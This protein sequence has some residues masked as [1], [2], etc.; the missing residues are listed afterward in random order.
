MSA[1]ELLAEGK[2]SPAVDIYEV[3]R[4]LFLNGQPPQPHELYCRSDDFFKITYVTPAFRQY[5][6]DFLRKLAAGES[7]IYV[8]PALFGA[9][10]SH[11]LAFVLHL[12]AL[13]RGCN[14]KGGCVRSHLA[15]H[16]I[17]VSTPDVQRVPNVA[18]FRHD[19][20]PQGVAAELW[21]AKIKD[22]LRKVVERYSPLVVIFDETQYFDMQWQGFVPWLQTLAEVVSESRGVYLFVSYALF[23]EQ[24]PQ[25]DVPQS[26]LVVQRMSH[27]KV[28]LD[29]VKNIAYVF[30]RWAGINKPGQVDLA[31]LRQVVRDEKLAEFEREVGEAYPFNPLLLRVMHKLADESVAERTRVQLTREL[32]R[33][34]SRA[35]LNAGNGLVTFAD[36]PEP[37]EL[38]VIGGPNA[39]YWNG[40]LS[41]YEDDI[42]KLG[43]R[44]ALAVLRHILLATFLAK[45]LPVA[46]LYP[47]EDDLILGAYD[48]S[49]V[50]PVDVREVLDK[51]ATDVGLHVDKLGDGYVYWFVGDE[52]DAIQQAMSMFSSNDGLE[53]V[54]NEVASLVE[55]RAGPFS[56][57][58][59][60]GPKEK[61]LRKVRVISDK[62]VW[63]KI[64]QEVD[65]SVLAVDLQGW[66]VEKRRNNL[67]LIE[68]DDSAGISEDA[69]ELLARLVPVKSI[70]DSA[71]ALGRVV[72]AVN[73]VL[74]NLSDYF[75]EL[76]SDEYTDVQ[77]EMEQILRNRIERWRERARQVL[78]NTV[79]IWLR[80][81]VA[82][83]TELEVKQLG[84]YLKEVSKN[85]HEAPG[86]IVET[87]FESDII[88]WKDFMR[89]GDLWSV[90]LNNRKLPP[91]PISFDGFVEAIRDYCRGASSC[92]C[93]FEV[94]GEVKWLSSSGCEVPPLD[95]KNV[96]VAPLIWREQLQGWA[97]ERFLRNLVQRSTGNSRFYVTYRRPSGEEVK[98]YV[99]D[100]LG[101]SSEWQY[102]MGGKVV[103]EQLQR[104]I[105]VRV[106]GAPTPDVERSPGTKV[107]VEVVGSDDLAEVRYKFD[108]VE[109]KDS[110]SGKRYAFH[111]NAPATPGIYRLEVEAVFRDGDNDR[112]VL[113]VRVKGKCKKL[114]TKYEV[115]LDDM[116]KTVNAMTVQDAES[117]LEY[118][119]RRGI[120]F[121]FNFEAHK[122]GEDAELKLTARFV[123]SSIE[124]KNRALR[125]LRAVQE[126]TPAASAK[127]EFR[128]QAVVVDEDMVQR[129]KGK[130]L[131]FEVEVEEEC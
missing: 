80:R 14:G 105:E 94:E 107:E 104:A 58:Y 128:Q 38:L 6:E 41:L 82:G 55:E 48:G 110:A 4:A 106:D 68:P 127:F 122:S 24:R 46:A 63:Q 101:N 60:S 98:R 78:K 79:N 33:T 29:T 8:L 130:S 9:G 49:R 90:Y 115:K 19:R 89:L 35:F 11:F 95:D 72:K 73:V 75:P 39:D 61:T 69:R 59:I 116:L 18:V 13:Y 52:A 27:V 99:D 67:F 56:A 66:G 91:V 45:L 119:V 87:L 30:R 85:A 5:A 62:D 64:L 86:Q 22:A 81:V 113:T 21:N 96:K 84:E 23:P 121:V 32:L 7:S 50:R 53:E 88:E 102:L 15:G 109:R 126:V 120:N 92:N 103:E 118:F 54:A 40:L 129:F 70:K 117:I 20:K 51:L 2:I 17:E 125:L 83:F 57:V 111:V 10:K 100:L 16:G 37:R 1:I 77:R 31:P 97:V 3:Y 42:K 76:K 36:L 12:I 124:G 123:V 26:L 74:N 25:T 47:T 112:R 44:A 131:A 65:K 108:G 71:I 28:S 43:D 93:I 114:V 34:L